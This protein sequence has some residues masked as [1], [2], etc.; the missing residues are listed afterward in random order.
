GQI[1]VEVDTGLPGNSL[2]SHEE[3]FFFLVA[4]FLSV[5]ATAFR[6]PKR[7]RQLSFMAFAITLVPL[8]ANQRRVAIAAFVLATLLLL[9][10]LYMTDPK[11]RRTILSLLLVCALVTPVYG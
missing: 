9:I 2:M 8:L 1:T 5:I 11:R 4:L 3:S 6:F 7:D 10:V